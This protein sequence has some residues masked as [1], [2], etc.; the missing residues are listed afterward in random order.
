MSNLSAEQLRQLGNGL[1]AKAQDMFLAQG[2]VRPMLFGIGFAEGAT[3]RMTPIKTGDDIQARFP[4][5]MAGLC[6]RFP[7]AAFVAESWVAPRNSVLSARDHPARMEAVV[8]HVCTR[9]SDFSAVHEIDR[10]R[11]TLVQKPLTQSRVQRGPMDNV[12]LVVTIE[13]AKRSAKQLRRVLT[14]MKP[15]WQSAMTTHI[16][17]FVNTDHVRPLVDVIYDRAIPEESALLANVFME[18]AF[19]IMPVNETSSPSARPM[20]WLAGLSVRCTL[21]DREEDLMLDQ[22]IKA[23]SESLPAAA[24]ASGIPFYVEPRCE[25]YCVTD[26]LAVSMA[27]NLLR[28]GL[29]WS[30]GSPV[31]PVQATV[32]EWLNARNT[33][34]MERLE[35]LVH[36]RGVSSEPTHLDL[37][38]FGVV[39]DHSENARSGYDIAAMP[40]WAAPISL[41]TLHYLDFTAASAG[42]A[43]GAEIRFTGLAP[44]YE[45]LQNLRNRRLEEH[46]SAVMARVNKEARS[47]ELFIE[48]SGVR[49]D[50][51]P[52][53]FQKAMATIWKLDG[54]LVLG[55]QEQYRPYEARSVLLD[56]MVTCFRK[57]G[58]MDIRVHPEWLSAPE[59]FLDEL[60]HQMFP[61]LTGGWLSPSLAL[62]PEVK[63][64]L[65]RL[66]WHFPDPDASKD[67]VI[68]ALPLPHL[69]IRLGLV[70]VLRQHYA[71]RAYSELRD[72][73]RDGSVPDD[74]ALDHLR[75]K[76]PAF[77]ALLEKYPNLALPDPLTFNTARLHWSKSPTLTVTPA[78]TERLSLTDL[79]AEVPAN[80]M[81]S[82]YPLVYIHFSSPFKEASILYEDGFGQTVPMDMVGAFV[83]QYSDVTRVLVLEPVWCA[84]GDTLSAIVSSIVLKVTDETQPL[85]VYLDNH[86]QSLG[87]DAPSAESEYGAIMALA[88]VLIYLGMKE[89]R[90]VD[91]PQR[92]STLRG[93]SR[94]SQEHQE[95]EI[96]KARGLY[97]HIRV[98]PDEPIGTVTL[99]TGRGRTVS[100]HFR[101]G[102]I[103]TYRVGPGRTHV[104]LKF[105]N[106]IIVNR[107]L[108]TENE[109]V[110]P[111]DYTLK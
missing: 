58:V 92:S 59:Q 71:P 103:H 57:A 111:R 101:R 50:R 4:S 109:D 37:V 107:Q 81:H 11:A 99:Y 84:P 100:P 95:K 82:P 55:V 97:D 72:I 76:N 40:R 49:F 60:G 83:K 73:L 36:V 27:L 32:V 6:E 96:H 31:P 75:A 41:E 51:Q 108:L 87:P 13:D 22:L 80:F 12:P 42:K 88:K 38:I 69:W 15:G 10:A 85:Q 63:G 2:A 46:L 70:D 77:G 1:F 64:I 86:Y 28:L 93:L 35:K 44:A 14:D 74:V 78:L 67:K 48:L 16:L 102:H 79:A 7:V 18:R 5:V 43:I 29:D 65:Q 98:G 8:V 30:T 62:I 94:K 105:V 21:V 104:E 53:S 90:I 52:E 39:M 9:D 19:S 25:T 110:T 66:E 34:E 89:A 54:G 68:R 3:P 26:I 91:S 45:T 56:K 23:L 61:D 24:R 106:P 33:K 17:G 47:D 20:A